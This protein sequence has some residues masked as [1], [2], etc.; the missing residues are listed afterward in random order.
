MIET[1]NVIDT[2][3]HAKDIAQDALVELGGRL[4]DADLIPPGDRQ[5]PSRAGRR[6]GARNGAR[7]V[8]VLLVL[9]I[10][11]AV[12]VWRRRA[13]ERFTARSRSRSARPTPESQRVQIGQP[14]GNAALT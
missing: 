11:A 13:A 7:L 12:V 3:E 9:G 1:Q 4:K 6:R 5:T 8:R 14:P 2:V 10:V